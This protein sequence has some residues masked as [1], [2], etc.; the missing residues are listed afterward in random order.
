MKTTHISLEDYLK[1]IVEKQPDTI[2]QFIA[3]IALETESPK[4][5]FQ[6]LISHGCISGMIG[7]LVY[8]YETHQFFDDFYKEIETLREDYEIIIPQGTD[9]KNYLAWAAVEIIAVQMYQDW[10]NGR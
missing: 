1:T 10:E 5:F 6:D 3:K 4:S 7:E 9:L 8:Y 2:A